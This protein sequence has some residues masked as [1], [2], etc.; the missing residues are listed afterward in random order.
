MRTID[1]RRPTSGSDE[2]MQSHDV[3]RT[4]RA[5]SE[6]ALKLWELG[7]PVAAI[8]RPALAPL[9]LSLSLWPSHFCLSPHV[10]VLCPRPL[11]DDS[12]QFAWNLLLLAMVLTVSHGCI[13]R[14]SSPFVVVVVIVVLPSRSAM[15]APETE[16]K[17]QCPFV[18]SFARP[19]HTS[20]G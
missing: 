18:R 16:P 12:K 11:L 13:V 8:D 19:A 3:V 15:K 1:D 10:A 14:R 20:S 17:Q 6:A 7:L 5:E 4:N 9:S 2:Q